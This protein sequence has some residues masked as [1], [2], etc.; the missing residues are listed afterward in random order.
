MRLQVPC[1]EASRHW[2]KEKSS[3][4]F[5]ERKANQP[6]EI[7]GSVAIGLLYRGGWPIEM[8]L[9]VAEQLKLGQVER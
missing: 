2:G 9:K 6:C 8:G 3:A 5:G 7:L 4:C 1:R